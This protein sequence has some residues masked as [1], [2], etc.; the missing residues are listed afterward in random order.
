VGPIFPAYFDVPTPEQIRR[1]ILT[2]S[3]YPTPPGSGNIF[4]RKCLEGIFPIT[5]NFDYAGD[6]YTVAAAPI[7]GDVITIAKPLAFYRVHGRNDGAMAEIDVKRFAG[8]LRRAHG[9]F[10]YMSGLARR[11]GLV[12][13][14]QAVNFS[15]ANVPYRTASFRLLPDTHQKFCVMRQ[16]PPSCHRASDCRPGWRY[17]LGPLWFCTCP[18]HSHDGLSCGGL[19]LARGH[20]G[21][22]GCSRS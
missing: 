8:E 15:I 11:A 10:A 1:W 13:R 22:E 7:L 2:T 9:R 17:S 5:D 14:P 12:V 21:S 20:R 4:S 16:Q 18:W 6:S 19:C 3:A